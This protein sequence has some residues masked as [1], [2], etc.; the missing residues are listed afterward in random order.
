VQQGDELALDDLGGGQV[1]PRVGDQDFLLAGS[2]VPGLLIHSRI[3]GKALVFHGGPHLWCK[4][5][6][7]D[8]GAKGMPE[9]LWMAAR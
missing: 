3:G 9:T 8:L 7:L 2:D 1:G 4:E 5:V 6:F